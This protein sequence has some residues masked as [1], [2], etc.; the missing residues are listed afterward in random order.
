MTP[1]ARTALRGAIRKWRN[2]VLGKA[3]GTEKDCPLCA[4]YLAK[5]CCGCPVRERSGK[6]WCVDTPYISHWLKLNRHGGFADTPAEIRAA[7]RVYEY[8]KGLL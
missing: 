7:F 3:P 5:R 2:V 4:L 1:E 6:M 8:L